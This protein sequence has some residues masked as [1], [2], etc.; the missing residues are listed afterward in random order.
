MY[1]TEFY[2]SLK[3]YFKDDSSFEAICSLAENKSVQIKNKE[4]STSLFGADMYVSASRVEDFY[5]CPFRYFC[6]FGLNA[7]PRNKAEIDP[8]QRGTLIHYVLEK[9]LSDVG[10]KALSKLGER[11]IVDLVDKYTNEFFMSEMGNINDLSLRFK[12]NYKRLSKL[13]YSVVIHL[14]KEFS[15][16]DFEAKAFELSIDKD[17]QVKPEVLSLDDGGT[18]Q[19]RGSIDRVDTFEKNNER[20]VRVVDYKSGRKVFNLSDIMQGLNLQMFIYLFSLCEDKTASLNGT[21]AGVLYMHSSRDI[22]PFDSKKSAESD[23]E[24]K[25][26]SSYKM[27]GIVLK[28]DDNIVASAMEK[29][30][31]GKYIPVKM[32]KNEELT[33]SLASLEEFGLIHK[34]VNSLVA[35]M[36]SELHSGN[37]SHSPVKNKNHKNTCDFCDYK[38]V[39]ANKKIIEC[40]VTEELT[41]EEVKKQLVEEFSENA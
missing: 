39:C 28:D 19:I 17:G 13:I 25:E 31:A 33:G 34:K 36:G 7:R 11:Q 32:N 23:I 24:Q 16:S 35:Q 4:T 22:F 40:R 6:K 1:N 20:Y 15:V 18:I 30:F 37:I 8:M 10:S 5:N 9:I 27:K 12:Y 14:A 41:D 38:D 21:P 2:S 29:D 26:D 3:E